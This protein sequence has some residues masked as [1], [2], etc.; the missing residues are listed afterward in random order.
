MSI[1]PCKIC[2]NGVTKDHKAI[3]CDLFAIWV[4]T[5]CNKINAQHII[6]YK[7]MKQS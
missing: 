5:K 7:I 4:H 1:F 3:C 2:S 6:C